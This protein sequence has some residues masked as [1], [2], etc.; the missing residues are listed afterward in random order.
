[1]NSGK[2]HPAS[3]E[4]TKHSRAPHE[5]PNGDDP[6]GVLLDGGL[7]LGGLGFATGPAFVTFRG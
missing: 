2:P 6:S 4:P 7:G 1:M 3:S 5:L